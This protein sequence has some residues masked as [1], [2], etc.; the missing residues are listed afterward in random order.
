MAVRLNTGWLQAA[1]LL[2]ALALP[3]ALPAT[4]RAET[5]DELYAKAKAEGAVV[6]SPG[7]SRECCWR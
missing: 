6:S 3:F 2:L 5:I 4:A 7:I 1:T